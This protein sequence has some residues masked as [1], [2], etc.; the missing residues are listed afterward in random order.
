MRRV[1]RLRQPSLLASS[2]IQCTTCAAPATL[3]ISATAAAAAAASRRT[4]STT[5][6]TPSRVRKF[7]WK[8]GD[9]PGPEDPYAADSS[10]ALRQQRIAQ[11]LAE[12]EAELA[13]FEADNQETQRAE[14]KRRQKPQ[15]RLAHQ[16]KN[17]RVWAPTEK[18]VTENGYVPAKTIDGL[19]EIG[20]IEGWWEQEGR[21]GKESEYVG[22][23][24]AGKVVEDADVC[25][26]LVRQAVVE[27]LAVA[28]SAEVQ[29]R[30]TDAWARGDGEGF[31][32]AT[33]LGLKIGE[34]GSV[35][36]ES[37][38]AAIEG[39]VAP[40][41][42]A[43]EAGVSEGVV[44]AAEAKALVE[45]WGEAWKSISLEDARFK[46]AVHKRVF[47]LTGHRVHDAKL[48]Q[49]NTVGDLIATIVTPPKPTKVA[50]AIAQQGELLDLP[51]VRVRDT[52]VTPID[53]EIEVGRW[54]VIKQELKKRGLPITGH[55]HLAKPV[56]RDWIQGKA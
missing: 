30:L 2:P 44:E 47:Q 8:G 28:G 52:R 55:K 3:P 45:A 46:F 42:E 4:L 54:K 1:P 7:L 56:Q 15:S 27:A 19:E 50:E 14:Q 21:W 41:L 11:E 17:K 51:N 13:A 24:S 16:I 37:D 5:P 48:A 22:F 38:A 39:V 12:A 26:A 31:S 43:Q 23:S 6:A 10:Q 29:G 35:S 53:K 32:R 18:E 49:I 40:L 20:G 25:A 34:D 9:A 36:L 33:A